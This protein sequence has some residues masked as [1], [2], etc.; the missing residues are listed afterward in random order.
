MNAKYIS[1]FLL[2]QFFVGNIH[3]QQ[4]I[5]D[6]LWCDRLNEIIKC[7]SIDMITDRISRDVHD[8][9]YIASFRPILTITGYP[10][11]ESIGKQY[12]KVTYVGYFYSSKK[13]D[14]KLIKQFDDCY[15]KIKSCLAPW[16]VARLKNG[17]ATLAVPDDYFITN[18]EDETTL[19]LDIYHDT[20]TQQYHVRLHIF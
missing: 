6:S 13:N 9:D 20:V 2:L 15:K 4:S 7:A 8:S 16:E 1:F 19:R 12:N 17:D 18:S 14:E 11:T 3:A 10:Q 5:S